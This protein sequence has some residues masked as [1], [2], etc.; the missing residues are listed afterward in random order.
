MRVSVRVGCKFGAIEGEEICA[1]SKINPSLFPEFGI[2]CVSGIN[3]NRGATDGWYVLVGFVFVW[4]DQLG[5]LA[6]GINAPGRQAR[7]SR[8]SVPIG[9]HWGLRPEYLD[10]MG[11]HPMIEF[12]GAVL[13]ILAVMFGMSGFA[14]LVVCTAIANGFSSP[15]FGKSAG[16]L[17]LS[18]VLALPLLVF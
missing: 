11:N 7:L 3:A 5:N 14:G 10:H 6:D 8:A 4:H 15:L 13:T 17:F 18:F 1:G 12:T 9:L 16:M 2:P